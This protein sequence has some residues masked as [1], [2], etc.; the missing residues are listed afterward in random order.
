M[1]REVGASERSCCSERTSSRGPEG[2]QRPAVHLAAAFASIASVASVASIASIASIAAF[3][4]PGSALARESPAHTSRAARVIVAQVT[5]SS[6][7][8]SRELSAALKPGP[9]IPLLPGELGGPLH[10][11]R[12]YVA[13]LLGALEAQ[14]TSLAAD[15]HAGN[16]AAA[17]SE[18]LT[19]HL[20]WLQIGQDDGAYG[21]FGDLGRQIDGT[22]AGLR[23]GTADPSFT[24]F[25]KL[26]F[27]IWTRGDL[28]AAAS[29]ADRLVSLVAALA[30]RGLAAELPGT[31]LGLGNWVL[32]PHEILEDALRDSLSGN[33]DYGSGTD[34]ASVTADVAATRELLALLTPALLI[35]APQLV[36]TARRELSTVIRAV[37]ATRVSGS[38]P[39]ITVLSLSQRERVNAAVGAALETLARVPDRLQVGGDI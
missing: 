39:A 35:R 5:R 29:D 6:P 15:L 4:A 26:E 34:L 12:Q 38:W 2:R 23:D 22:S 16:V 24:G 9:V 27:D 33:D 20:T 28:G 18:W 21:A 13:R 37:D 14:V 8:S 10:G 3:V 25:H 31:R 7:G 19:A 1:V 32:R 17:E 30:P 11:Y 36:A